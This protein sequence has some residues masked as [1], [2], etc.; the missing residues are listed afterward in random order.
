VIDR[1]GEVRPGRSLA[2]AGAHTKGHNSNSIG[3]CLI[4]GYRSQAKDSF[5]QH[6]TE[7]QR[8][9]L[10]EIIQ[11]LEWQH[12]TI[13]KISGHNEYANK[14]CPGFQVKPFIALHEGLEP[15]PENR[16]LL[17]LILEILRRIFRGKG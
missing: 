14:G 8:Q 7:F 10:I 9:A 2:R 3:I 12:P 15:E 13:A 17:S 1:N 16:G 5:E 4:G 6:Y 11:N